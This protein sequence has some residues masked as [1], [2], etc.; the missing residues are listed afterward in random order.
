RIAEL[1]LLG[2]Q[3]AVEEAKALKELFHVEDPQPLRFARWL[4]LVW[5]TSFDSKDLGLLQG[6][7]GRSMENGELVNTLVGDRIVLTVLISLFTIVFTWV[8]ALPL[9]IYSAVRPYSLTDYAL[10]LLGFVGMSVPGFL[11]ALLLIYA[12]QRWLGLDIT[13]LF[14]A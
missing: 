1:E 14:S 9:G 10:T 11:L 13:G 5:F 8:I 3:S 12:S 7:L 6:H 2:D 4:G